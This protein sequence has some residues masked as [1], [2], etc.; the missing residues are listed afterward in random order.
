ML[1]KMVI[2]KE[3]NNVKNMNYNI[4]KTLSKE[5]NKLPLLEMFKIS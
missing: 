1:L 2:N 5:I 3:I 4:N